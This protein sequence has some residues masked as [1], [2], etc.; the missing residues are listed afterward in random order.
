M[1]LINDT[2]MKVYSMSTSPKFTLNQ[3][4]NYLCVSTTLLILLIVFLY[5][6]LCY[7][8]C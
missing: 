8:V 6:I 4:L 2:A 5:E 7:L 3:Q 1:G